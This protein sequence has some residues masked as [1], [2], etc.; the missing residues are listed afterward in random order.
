YDGTQ[1]YRYFI[2][3]DVQGET[4]FLLASSAAVL[5]NKDYAKTAERLLDYLFYTSEF[6][7]GARNNK[8]SSSYGLISWANSNLN[9]FFG[10][11]N[12]WPNCT[13]PSTAPFATSVDGN[14]NHGG[15]T[16]NTGSGTAIDN[17]PQYLVLAFIMKL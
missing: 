17:R 15:A 7:K 14:H 6:R 5:G 9:A 2:R 12:A 4:S 10:D 16:A 13:N 3:S 8:D 11:D 1:K